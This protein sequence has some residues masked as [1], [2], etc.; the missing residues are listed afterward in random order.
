MCVSAGPA[1]CAS[2]PAEV[3]ASDT[4]ALA[5]TDASAQ[6]VLQLAGLNYGSSLLHFSVLLA[7][8][9]T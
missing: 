3:R 6:T 8:G 4:C 9:T 7:N 2:Q 5:V 1:L